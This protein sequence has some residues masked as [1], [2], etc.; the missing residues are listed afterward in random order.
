MQ[1]NKKYM[2][3]KNQIQMWHMYCRVCSLMEQF[4]FLGKES[5]EDILTTLMYV[6][7]SNQPGLVKKSQNLPTRTSTSQ[8]SVFFKK[9]NYS[10]S[11]HCFNFEP[12]HSSTPVSEGQC[13]SPSL[14]QL[15]VHITS[16]WS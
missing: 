6:N 16:L 13:L 12:V 2:K 3:N 14:Q 9:S 11:G 7:M 1:K 10:F 15:C 4:D 8:V 5:N